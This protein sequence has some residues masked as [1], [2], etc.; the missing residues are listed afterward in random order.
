MP[1]SL[2]ILSGCSNR[3][4]FMYAFFTTTGLGGTARVA[5]KPRTEGSLTRSGMIRAGA[6]RY[7]LAHKGDAF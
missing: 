6:T 7:R 4:A 5:F 1:T 3:T 2:P